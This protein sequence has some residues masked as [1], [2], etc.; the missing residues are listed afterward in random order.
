MNQ[1]RSLSQEVVLLQQSTE[2]PKK[3]S[4]FGSSFFGCIISE[5]FLRI[6]NQH[7][8]NFF[9]K[10][11]TPELTYFKGTHFSL[12]CDFSYFLTRTMKSTVGILK[13]RKNL[14][15][16]LFFFPMQNCMNELNFGKKVT[17]SLHPTCSVHVHDRATL[18]IQAIG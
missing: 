10:I 17:K 12:W 8:I 11:P 3:K 15:S 1:K 13:I 14:F 6:W 9:F 16:I 18:F 2:S 4:P 5:I 7:K